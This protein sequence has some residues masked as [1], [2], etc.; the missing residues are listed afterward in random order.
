MPRPTVFLSYAHQD[1]AWKDRIAGHLLVLGDLEVWDDRQIAPGESWFPAIEAAVIR[2]RV[3]ILVISANFLTSRFILGEEIPRLL[4]LRQETRL[5]VVPV[6]ARPCAWETVDWLADMQLFPKGGRALSSLSRKAQVDEELATLTRHVKKLLKEPTQTVPAGLPLPARHQVQDLANAAPAPEEA[7]YPQAESTSSEA[8]NAAE[9]RGIPALVIGL[10]GTGVWT[11]RALKRLFHALPP[12]ERVPASF[13]AFDF[14]REVS[15]ETADPQSHFAHLEETELFPLN[16]HAIQ[17]LLSNLDSSE[18]SA[19]SWKSLLPWLP[20][21]ARV[22]SAAGTSQLRALGRLGLFLNDEAIERAV[23]RKLSEI[24]SKAGSSARNTRVFLVSSVAG[25]TGSGMLIDMA[26][27]SRR[28]QSRPRVFAYLLLPDVFQDIDSGGRILQ[29]SYACLKELSVLK[30]QQI[31]FEAQYDR[32]PP[33]L[34][35]VGGEEPFARIFLYRGHATDARNS[36]AAMIRMA[37]SILG[38]LVPAIQEKTLAITS[39]TLA[40]HPHALQQSKPECFSTAS[41]ISL[42]LQPVESAKK[43]AREAAEQS[44]HDVFEQLTLSPQR[45]TFSMMLFQGPQTL[46]A[47]NRKALQSFFEAGTYQNLSSP[48]T[49]DSEARS[50]I[51]IYSEDLF[52]PLEHIRFLGHYFRA[53]QQ[54]RHK[55]LLHIDQRMLDQ[56]AFWEVDNRISLALP[57]SCGNPSCE[58]S[59]AALPRAHRIC[60]SCWELIR[61]RCGNE[62]CSEEAL[63]LHPQGRTM[64][65]PSC[66][67][68]NYAAWWNCGQHGKNE[69]SI[70]TDEPRCPRCLDA[71]RNNPIIWP[72]ERISLRPDLVDRLACPHCIALNALDPKHVVYQLPKEMIPFYR[73]GVSGSERKVFQQLA[74]FHRF[75]DEVRCPGCRTFLI[76]IHHRDGSL[77][78]LFRVGSNIFMTPLDPHYYYTVLCG[79]CQFPLAEEDEQCPRCQIPLEECAVCSATTHTRA[80]IA[81]ADPYTGAKRCP[82]C[83]VVRVPFGRQLV[84]EFEGCFCTNI[85]GCPAGGL[86]LQS[87]E[88]AVLQPKAIHCPICNNSGLRPLDL[89]N[90]IPLISRC[91]FCSTCFGLSHSWYRGWSTSWDPKLLQSD[92]T[93]PPAHPCPLCGRC[94]FLDRMGLVKYISIDAKGQQQ[95]VALQ[96]WQYLRVVELGRAFILRRDDQSVFLNIFD[97]WFRVAGTPVSHELENPLTVGEVAGHLLKGTLLPTAYRFLS[98]RL[99]IFLSTWSRKLPPSG[100]DYLV[101]GYE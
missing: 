79:N 37:E 73:N 62:G 94:D 60:P 6:I 52:H 89:R 91:I 9:S 17:D 87:E 58:T 8:S 34:V 95:E 86:L 78:L 23:R 99:D 74:R 56:A 21:R 7:L 12:E 29:N 51:R 81:P 50:T 77:R 54:E 13:L 46:S 5:V 100:I 53:Y 71:H 20:D 19:Y 101:T 2:S 92:E 65:C 76:P 18:D 3:A 66:G 15:L 25:G 22:M 26:Y 93:Q 83:Y 27:I 59:I 1:E 63:H 43:R 35:P 24:S 61:S 11:L 40:T 45:K 47:E 30:D 80:P 48:I 4:K 32:I 36:R 16:P 68:F 41:S 82:L 84:S 28:Q 96:K 38:Q 39:N 72:A 33:A 75:P 31:P 42:P 64:T 69:V 44:A 10:G 57:V 55:E 85:Y 90:F 14:D 97:S 67:Q 88:F 98:N 70:P 49:Y